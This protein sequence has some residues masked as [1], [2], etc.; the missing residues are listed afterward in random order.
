MLCLLHCFLSKNLS[1]AVTVTSTT[2][3][4]WRHA[5]LSGGNITHRW[6]GYPN[7]DQNN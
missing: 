7:T 6:F 3:T 1:S 5:S 2:T 4:L